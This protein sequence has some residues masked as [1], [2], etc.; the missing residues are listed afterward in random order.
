VG[1]RLAAA[2]RTGPL[3]TAQSAAVQAAARHSL[4]DLVAPYLQ[5]DGAVALPV[6]FI[7]GR[8]SDM[9]AT[10]SSIIACGRF[11]QQAEY[12]TGYPLLGRKI[13]LSQ[14]QLDPLSDDLV[15]EGARPPRIRRSEQ[16][17][18]RDGG[19]PAEELESKRSPK[20]T[21][22]NS[23]AR[24]S[25]CRRQSR[26]SPTPVEQ[27]QRRPHACPLVGDAEPFEFDLVHRFAQLAY[28]IPE[29][30]EVLA[31]WRTTGAAGPAT[32]ATAAARRGG[33]PRR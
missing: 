23:S 33:A 9:I 28:A 22:V 29:G 2:I 17:R 10:T 4:D 3:L 5:A 1:R 15:G 7:T 32:W 30:L 14:H 8:T 31:G 24:P 25:S 20:A 19:V 11:G 6:G 26:L 12:P 27:E 13:G 21:T 16:K 18:F